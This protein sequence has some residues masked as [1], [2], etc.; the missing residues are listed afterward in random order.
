VI[1]WEVVEDKPLSVKE[2]EQRFQS[3][4]ESVW[5]NDK[6]MLE[7]MKFWMETAVVANPKTGEYYDDWKARSALMNMYFKV[8]KKYKPDTIINII[9]AFKKN[10]DDAFF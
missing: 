7:M 2:Q 3:L 4:A 10:D 6:Y 1:H 9:N 5:L 8:M